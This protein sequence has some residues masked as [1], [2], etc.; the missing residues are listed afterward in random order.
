MIYRQQRNYENLQRVTYDGVGKYEVPP[1]LPSDELVDWANANWLGCNYMRGCEDPE[2]HVL[3]F[4]VDDYQFN[5][6]WTDPDRYIPKLKRFKAVCSPDFSTYIDFPMAIQ[7]YNHYRK[8]WLA[9]YW[10]ANGVNVIPTISWSDSRSFEWCFDG[11][12]T[13]TT[14][15]ISSVGTQMGGKTKKLFLDGYN[16]MIR[17]LEPKEIV[18]MGILPPE[19]EGP[20]ISI[21]AFQERFKKLNKNVQEGV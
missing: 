5:R 19:C 9:A 8:H 12:P 3:H 10:Q 21:D 16:E 4:F 13:H 6:F 11:E 1:I 15:A 18:V 7:I 17:R 14:V 20:I 2:D